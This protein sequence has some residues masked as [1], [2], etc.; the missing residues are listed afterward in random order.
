MH[1]M[2]SSPPTPAKCPRRLTPR[3]VLLAL[4]LGL[5]AWRGVGWWLSPRPLYTLRYEYEEDVNSS[6]A[7]TLK[8]K[9][10]RL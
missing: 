9:P 2:P 4:V 1:A 3:S 6:R 8:A 10:F 5:A 7:E